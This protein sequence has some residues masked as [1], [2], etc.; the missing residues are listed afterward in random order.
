M[1]RRL[2]RAYD[3][4]TMPGS[5]SD[6]IEQLMQRELEKKERVPRG[7]YAQ[8]Q[9]P[10]RKNGSIWGAAAAAV[11]LVLVLSVGSVGLMLHLPQPEPAGMTAPAATETAPP[12]TEETTAEDHYA[13]ATSL[14]AA[15]VEAAAEKI[16]QTILTQDWF[17]LYF[18]LWPGCQGEDLPLDAWENF[19]NF[20]Y[21][22][23]IQPAFL[24]AIEAESCRKMFCSSDGIMMGA[25][26]QIW[27]NE[28]DGELKITAINEMLAGWLRYTYR[29]LEDGTIQIQHYQGSEEHV[30][31][32]GTIEGKRVT[33]IGNFMQ[34]GSG[35]FQDWRFIRSVTIPDSVTM[36]DERTFRNCTSLERV[37]IGAGVKEIGD[38]AFEDCANLLAVC[39]YGDAPA[40]GKDIFAGSENVTVYCNDPA[41]GWTDTWQGRPTANRLGM[42]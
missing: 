5:C 9:V 32:P 35:A 2:Q 34:E 37:D 23:E 15:E 19:E 18:Y 14:P 12:V 29:T 38:S 17:A 28:V 36:I 26:G 13:A 6:R 27:L 25:E 7:S 4:M 24:E 21:L 30:A 40:A 31:I 10:V 11:L 16:R 1:K 20:M 41:N 8:I 33:R 42:E 22:N 39:F 3:S